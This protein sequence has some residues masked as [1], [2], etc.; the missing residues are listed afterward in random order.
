LIELLVVVAIIAVL[1]AVLLPALGQARQTARMVQCQSQLRA[2]GQGMAGYANDHSD[3]LPLYYV[4][5]SGLPRQSNP[6]VW[7]S[8]LVGGAHAGFA[9]AGTNYIGINPYSTNIYRC[10][11]DTAFVIA[12]STGPCDVTCSFSYNDE[13][14]YGCNIGR[15]IEPY[16]WMKLS[17]F[18]RPDVFVLTYEWWDADRLGMGSG[19]G[20]W[21]SSEGYTWGIGPFVATPY[22]MHHPG[23]FGGNTLFGDLHVAMLSYDDAL[24][25][26]VHRWG[27]KW[28]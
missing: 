19:A 24:I 20:M 10:P 11:N 18:D 5:P 16:R 28:W 4:T 27:W 6:T 21:D 17:S 26:D 9:G 23:Q 25:L 3:R 1:V 22:A 2:I 14:Y 15:A 12:N 7:C 13:S 8:M